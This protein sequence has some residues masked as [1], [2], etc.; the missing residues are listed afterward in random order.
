MAYTNPRILVET[1]PRHRGEPGPRPPE[2]DMLTAHD[3]VTMDSRKS[4]QKLGKLANQ[5]RHTARTG[6]VAK[7]GT[8]AGPDGPL[9]R[10]ETTVRPS[11][12]LATAV[13]KGQEPP[14][15]FVRGQRTRSMSYPQQIRGH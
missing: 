13:C 7:D 3:A 8:S 4:R 14:H 10:I 11:P 1:G 15:A 2:A 6:P 9:G 12:R 5:A